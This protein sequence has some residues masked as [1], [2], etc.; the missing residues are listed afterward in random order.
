MYKV[1]PLTASFMIVSIVG[2]LVAAFMIDDL[3]W[4]FTMQLFFAVMFI[5]SFVSMTKG[6]AIT[7]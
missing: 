1:A 4:R 6:P 2:F 7:K 5:A 3:S